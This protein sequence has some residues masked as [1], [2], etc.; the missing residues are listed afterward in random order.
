[1]NENCPI[2]KVHMLGSFSLT[3]GETPISFRRNSMTKAMKLLQIL[4]H[5]SE[6]GISR[7]RLLESLYGR[8]E[9]T[10]VANNLR[11]TVHRLKKMLVEAG[12][13]EY[14]YIKIKKG[15]Y[16]WDSPMETEI[17]ALVFADLVERAALSK[18]EDEK[19]ELLIQACE[20]YTGEFLPGLSGEE[21]VVL[22]SIEY[23]KKYFEV[24]RQICD[25][26]K[27]RREYEKILELCTPACEMYPFDEWQS[28]KVECYIALKRYKEAIKEYEDAA[29]L[30]FEELGISP[31]D[32]MLRLFESMSD[33]ISL[34][35]Q[36]IADIKES[37]KEAER[38]SG[39][40]YCTFPSFRDGYRLMCRVIERN[41]QS[42]YL[43]VCTITDGKGYPIENTD[44]LNIMADEL[45]YT[46]KKS[47]RKGDSYT[48][49]SPSQF[50]ILLVG[51]NQENCSIVEKRITKFY[52]R[53]HKNWAQCL[54][55]HVSSIAD[56]DENAPFRGFDHS[57][58]LWTL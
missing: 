52:S 31:S 56:M 11:V 39:A 3:Y 33:Q 48:R 58:N 15:I 34:K 4:L 18:E 44:R 6:R 1:M 8:E 32:K 30:F 36:M 41:G 13:P 28:V 25:I 55:F 35:P 38:E 42:V 37:L 49:Y 21:W 26:L 2:L 19:A 22:E 17:D 27:S 53:E 29:K 7:E 24:L 50:L 47:L 23:K 10:D 9:L 46:L 20:M 51:T 12:L 14:D 5:C 54:E 40:F 57:K 45:H 16:S 43:M